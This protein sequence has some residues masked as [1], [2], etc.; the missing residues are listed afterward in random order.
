MDIGIL[1]PFIPG[2]LKSSPA[3]ETENQNF[4]GKKISPA[5]PEGKIRFRMVVVQGAGGIDILSQMVHIAQASRINQE[6]QV[7]EVVIVAAPLFTGEYVRCAE[8]D[9]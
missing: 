4:N 8:Y 3:I 9:H 5:K 2:K 7:K 1:I 6:R